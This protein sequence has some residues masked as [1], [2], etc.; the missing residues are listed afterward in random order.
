VYMPW[1]AV[2]RLFIGQVSTGA[3]PR[4]RKQERTAPIA[5]E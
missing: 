5:E 4:R 1:C 2:A 3:E